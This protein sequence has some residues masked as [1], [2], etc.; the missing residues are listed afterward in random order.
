[1]ASNMIKTWT[2]ELIKVHIQPLPYKLQGIQWTG[3]LRSP[4]VTKL[5]STTIIGFGL[6][7]QGHNLK[8]EALSQVTLRW[9]MV[10]ATCNF[11]C[12]TKGRR[13]MHRWGKSALRVKN[14]PPA[15]VA[16]A[17]PQDPTYPVREPAEW[18]WRMGSSVSFRVSWIGDHHRWFIH[19]TVNTHHP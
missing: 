7:C 9:W 2:A 15:G 12:Q 6:Y 18:C 19:R 4:G 14:F 1:M 5:G 11:Q 17:V 16:V 8:C 3:Y 13:S 10:K